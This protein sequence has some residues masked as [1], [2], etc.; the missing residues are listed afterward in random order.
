MKKLYS[1]AALLV[2]CTLTAFA[3]RAMPGLWQTKTLADGTEVRVELCGDE[4]AHFWRTAEGETYIVRDGVLQPVTLQEIAAQSQARRSVAGHTAPARSMVARAQGRANTSYIG[5]KKGL[6]ILVEFADKAFS[7]DNPQ[8]YYY[9]MANEVG[10][11]EGSQSGSVHDYFLAQ[12]NGQFDLTFDVVGPVKMANGYAYYGGDEGENTDVNLGY[13]LRTAI[14]RVDS[15]VKWSD[16]DWDGDGQVE[17]IFYIY[18][19]RGQATGGGD[20][21]IWPHKWNLRNTAGGDG[22]PLEKQGMVLDVYACSNEMYSASKVAGIG[23]ICHEFSHCLGLPD[24]YDVDGGGNYGMG[25]WDLMCSGNYNNNGYTPAGYSA[26]EKMMAGWLEPIELTSSA[27]ITGMLPQSEGGEAYIVYNPGNRNEYYM[28]ESRAKSGWDQYV[29]GEGLMVT[30]ID[31]D[32][33]IFHYHNSP[34][35]TRGGN[36]H[37]R[38]TMYHAD[39]TR[40]TKDEATDLFPN[41]LLNVL[42]D[43]STPATMLYNLNTDGTKKMGVRFNRIARA[44]DGTVSFVFGD[45]VEADASV[46]FAESFDDCNDTGGNDN[47]WGTFRNADGEFR[48]DAEGWEST[49]AWGARHCARIGASMAPGAEGVHATTREI[50]FQGDC[51]LTFRAAPYAVEGDMALGIGIEGTGLTLSASSVALTS[52]TWNE[53][54]I[55]ITGKGKGKLKFS[56]TTRFYLDDVLVR[57]NNATG[58][59]D[60]IMENGEWIMENGQSTYDMTGRRVAG[61]AGHGV[62]V[63]GGKKVVK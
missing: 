52:M 62:F 6:I 46:L 4:F 16:Y 23:T 17:Q 53:Y 28:L 45:L 55:T 61:T 27:S 3:D 11:S 8:D 5:S 7:M 12:S 37:E 13:M 48:T 1:L 41:G 34:N 38:F 19:G 36:D 20:D 10:F 32:E 31:Y 25:N 35:S 56:G 22:L 42:S 39:N 2:L 57:D 15:Q 43:Y 63:R 14:A 21:T 58:I 29:P 40:S 44:E 47:N 9:R 33:E 24:L 51:T 26:W 18:A 59:E 49:K 50:D 30:H 54:S 60:V